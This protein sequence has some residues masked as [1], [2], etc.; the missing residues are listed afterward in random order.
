MR[1]IL[2]DQALANAPRYL[3]IQLEP[4]AIGSSETKVPGVLI[5]I[6][7]AQLSAEGRIVLLPEIS[8]EMLQTMPRRA[9][10]ALDWQHEMSL[11]KV[12]GLQSELPDR[13]AL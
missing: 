6:G 1:R 8:I 10:G 13:N 7:R 3:D 11:G 9:E 4:A 12:F 2:V 5:P